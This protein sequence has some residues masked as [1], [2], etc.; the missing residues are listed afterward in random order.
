MFADTD[1]YILARLSHDDR[2]NLA[3]F[4]CVN[5]S[6][7]TAIS[8]RSRKRL[9]RHSED[10]NYFLKNEALEEQ[11]EGYNTTFLVKK[12][13]KIIGY[14]SLCSDAIRLD[15]SERRI[16]NRGNTGVIGYETFPALKIARLAVHKDFQKC[17]IGKMLIN[18]AV[19]KALLMREE[20]GGVRFITLDCFSHRYSYYTNERIGFIKN[21]E[22]VNHSNNQK[23]IS[24]RL[25][26]DDYLDKLEKI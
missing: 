4:D 13:E 9:I 22:Q 23:P 15:Y 1:G 25:D 5:H 7:F 17:G 18:Y 12:D 21:K 26:I 2:D 11:N 20:V 6:E 3:H 8:P 16:R 10:M 19:F 14:M 24:L